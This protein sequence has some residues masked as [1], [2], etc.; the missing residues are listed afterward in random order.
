MRRHHSRPELRR[1]LP[2]LLAGLVLC[3]MGIAAMVA[4]DLGL[5]PWDVLHQ[6]IARRTGFPIGTIVILVGV[7][8]MLL[9]IPL[10]ERPGLG[11]VLNAILI[12]I[13][14]DLTLLWLETPAIGSPAEGGDR[15]VGVD[16]AAVVAAAEVE[17]GWRGPG[18][19]G[20]ARPCR[21]VGP[22][23]PR[24]RD[25]ALRDV[26]QVGVVPLA[27]VAGPVGHGDAP[28]PPVDRAGAHHHTGLDGHDRDALVGE[29]VVALVGPPP[30]RG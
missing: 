15:R 5:G 8:V 4:A 14:I 9:W 3:G 22:P 30:E 21:S 6:G 17:V 27:A 26:P 10:R 29:D 7:A 1:R 11:T 24:P 16:P 20:P 18:V 28:E 13:V 23:R 12:G 19:A 25:D 2:R